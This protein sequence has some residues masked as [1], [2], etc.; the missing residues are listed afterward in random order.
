MK[1]EVKIKRLAKTV[2]QLRKKVRKLKETLIF[3]KFFYA[4]K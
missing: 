4:K 1:T 3:E 2:L